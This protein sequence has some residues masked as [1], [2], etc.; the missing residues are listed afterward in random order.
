MANIACLMSKE[1]AY[2]YR[3]TS[4]VCDDNVD[5]GKRHLVL[6]KYTV[7]V[8]SQYVRTLRGWAHSGN[9]GGRGLWCHLK[10]VSSD[11][12]TRQL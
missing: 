11:Q 12:C 6:S 8:L 1:A 3:S 9:L 10:L 5:L 4:I 7:R 2:F